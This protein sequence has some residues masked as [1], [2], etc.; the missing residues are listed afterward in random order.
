MNIKYCCN[1]LKILMCF[2]EEYLS[3]RICGLWVPSLNST[4]IINS[5]H[6]PTHTI[7]SPPRFSH[8]LILKHI[9]IHIFIY[10]YI[11]VHICV[12]VYTYI[13]IHIYI[14]IHKNTQMKVKIKCKR[15]IRQ[16]REKH[17]EQTH[18]KYREMSPS[19]FSP[20][21]LLLLSKEASLSC[22]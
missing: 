15:P 5:H 12:C 21:P 6:I 9:Y 18:K 3:Y 10:T 19:S 2:V 14:Y 20:D 16:K 13:H 4:Q 1:Y 17:K 22:G 7:V 8:S 11:Y